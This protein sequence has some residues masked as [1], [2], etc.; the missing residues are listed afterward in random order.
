MRR[1]RP[2][3]ATVAALLAVAV[4]GVW[5]VGGLLVAPAQRAVA[6]PT[7]LAVEPFTIDSPN[8]PLAAWALP[9]DS[10]RGTVVLMHGVRADRGS[11]RERM[12]LFGEAGYHVVAFDFQ[13]H[14]ESPGDAITFGAR[15]RHDAVAAVAAARQRFGGPVAVVGQSMGGAAALL[16]G[17]ALDADA[18]VVEAVYAD[19]E[20]ATRNRIGM[21]LGPLAGPLAAVL[22][23]QLRPRLG[24]SVDSLRPADAARRVEAPLLVLVGSEDTHATPA[25]S[26]QIHDAATGPKALWTVEGAAHQD[27]YRFAPDAYARRVLGFLDTH[28]GV[29]GDDSP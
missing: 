11:Q 12:R 7:D 23:A 28:L 4:G 21:R 2:A 15:E 16:A 13:A 18:L 14:G 24:L 29:R 8:G 26:R 19:I 25:E 5:F 10:A 20:R 6:E 1:L 3:L 27:L 17:P 22:T 9:A